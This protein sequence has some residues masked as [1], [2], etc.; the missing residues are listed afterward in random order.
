MKKANH[1]R[2][3]A[4]GYSALGK[5]KARMYQAAARVQELMAE[6]RA[7]KQH[8][9]SSVESVQSHSEPSQRFIDRS[10][11]DR[12]RDILGMLIQRMKRLK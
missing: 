9:R 3:L 7:E 4:I 12:V 11:R 8:R 6:R 10:S 2:A 1:Y 5:D